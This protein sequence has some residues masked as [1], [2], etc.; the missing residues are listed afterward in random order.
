MFN[1]EQIFKTKDPHIYFPDKYSTPFILP[2]VEE[3]LKA[4]YKFVWGSLKEQKT[5]Q[6]KLSRVINKLFSKEEK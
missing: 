2:Y 1:H 4:G 5:V 6:S 3:R